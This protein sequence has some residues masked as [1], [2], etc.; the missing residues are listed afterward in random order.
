[1]N[2]PEYQTASEALQRFRGQAIPKMLRLLKPPPKLTVADWADENR[3]LSPEASAEPGQWR[4]SRVE[5]LRGIMNAV[6]DPVVR[7]VAFMKSAQV[8]GTEAALNV[9]GYYIDHDPSPVL[10]VVPTIDIAL[11]WSKDRFSPM[12]RDTPCLRGKVREPRTRN[13][14]NT[15]LHKVFPGG[16][17]TL[18]G[19]NSPS[20]LATRPVRI[21]VCDDVDRFPVSAG[22]EGDPIKLATKRT[23]TFWNRKLVYI[24]TPTVRGLSK[25]EALFENSNMS[26]YHVPCPRC[27]AYQRLEWK[28]VKF[29]KEDLNSV[30]YEC[31][32]CNAILTEADKTKMVRS[33]S[34]IAEHP[35][36]KEN[37]GFFVNELYSPWVT[38]RQTVESFLEAKKRPETLRVWVNTVLGETWEEEEVRQVS[39]EKIA[40]RIEKYDKV[41]DTVLVLT[42][43]VDVQDH[44]LEIKVKGWGKGNESWHIDHEA[45]EGS[46]ATAEVWKQLDEYLDRNWV[47][48]NGLTL[49]ISATMIDTGGHFTNEVYT[50]CKP[51]LQRRVVPIVGRAGAGRPIVGRPSRSNRFRMPLFA[52]GVDTAKEL[53][54]ARM[55]IEDFGPGYMHF[56]EPKCDEEYFKQ[57]TAEKLVTKYKKGFASRI[58]VKTR[59]R[60]EAL[61]MEVYALAAFVWLNPNMESLAGK[62][63]DRLDTFHKEQEAA[64][65]KGE[66]VPQQA[67][68]QAKRKPKPKRPRTYSVKMW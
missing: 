41:P 14:S 50:Y 39:S 19:A 12:L 6:N 62:Q 51:R 48:E 54:Y 59:A 36:R 28:Q 46:P 8:A 11:T 7:S 31:A 63:S 23:T 27:G 49:R 33:G 17:I 16:H 37:V 32:K 10:V 2:F 35:E 1:M 3:I 44:R 43:G 9:L 29:E 56:N 13:S 38:W 4:T 53:I 52:L 34:W 18:A 22:S 68:I 15:L 47:C 21:V 26:F 66:E 40:G 5:Y 55:E 57:L 42:A 64:K 20:S 25:I 30:G 65:D 58:W 61:D 67:S 24:S 45:F 60:N